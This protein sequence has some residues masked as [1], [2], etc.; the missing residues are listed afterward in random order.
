MIVIR[1]IK[2]F[3]QCIL[4]RAL[5]LIMAITSAIISIMKNHMS[6]VAI[7]KEIGQ[8]LRR[9]RLN[10]DLTQARLAERT[11]LGRGTIGKAESGGVTTL[12]TLV[13]ILR[14]LRL[15]SRLDQ[16]LPEPSISP[17]QLAQM[18]GRERQRAS[19]ERSKKR[20]VKNQWK[21]NS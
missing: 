15:L 19:R 5:S 1:G 7:L 6:D 20:P 11:G 14:G 2:V 8:R 17:V 4:S 10:Q 13:A 9:E 3:Y 21:W 12:A 16:L 18:K